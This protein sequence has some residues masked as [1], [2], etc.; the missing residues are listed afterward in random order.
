MLSE[1]AAEMKKAPA[2][3]GRFCGFPED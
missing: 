3:R 1:M 2:M